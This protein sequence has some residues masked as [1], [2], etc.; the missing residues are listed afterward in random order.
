MRRNNHNH[1]KSRLG[2]KIPDC[3]DIAFY[4]PHHAGPGPL[5]REPMRE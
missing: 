2:G 3:P 4:G 1:R 5:V